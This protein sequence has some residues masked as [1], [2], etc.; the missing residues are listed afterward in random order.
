MRLPRSFHKACSSLSL[1]AADPPAHHSYP[2]AH[3]HCTG[4]AGTASTG[5]L[6]HKGK[7]AIS[8][9]NKGA[10]PLQH[11][12]MSHQWLLRLADSGISDWKECSHE[13]LPL[14]LQLPPHHTN[15]SRAGR[16]WCGS[17]RSTRHN[18]Q[19]RQRGPCI[20]TR[21]CGHTSR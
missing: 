14:V 3:S 13:K 1:P 17:P 15:R 19:K 12:G 16:L 18:D 6:L 4:M 11:P 8:L 7:K 20:A 5:E 9:H 21:S 2:L 10:G